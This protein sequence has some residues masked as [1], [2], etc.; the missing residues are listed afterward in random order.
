MRIVKLDAIN[1]TNTYLKDLS[2]KPGT[3]DWT[4]VS[5]EY[6]SL[7]RGQMLNTWES[8]RG[9]NLMFSV[10]IRFKDLNIKNRF[11]LNCAVSIGIYNALNGFGIPQLKIKWPNDIM[12][13]SKKLGGVLIENSLRQERIS[14]SIIGIG[15]NINQ[16]EFPENLIQAVSLKNILKTDFNRDEVLIKLI[17]SLK[18]QIDKLNKGEY[19]DLHK[20][21][22]RN[23]FRKGEIH[24]FEDATGSKFEAVIMGVTEQGLLLMEHKKRGLISY[25][26]KEIK[27]L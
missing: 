13:V 25:D 26:F 23:L 17:E 16:T 27:F 12:A 9:K 5:T 7:G 20:I 6:Q 24:I 1:S 21:Y 19:E 8:D 14:Q 11:Y 3:P 18:I 15:L 22:E 4:V 10:L 2:K